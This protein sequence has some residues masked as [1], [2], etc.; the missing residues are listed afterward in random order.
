MRKKTAMAVPTSRINI[1][2][3]LGDLEI[4]AAHA[5]DSLSITFNGAE[6]SPRVALS[7][8]SVQLPVP[9]CPHS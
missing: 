3:T 9:A 7:A 8:V 2:P 1:S 4:A 6:L 5:I